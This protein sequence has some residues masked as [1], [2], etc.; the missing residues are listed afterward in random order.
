MADFVGSLKLLSVITKVNGNG[1]VLTI[2][3]PHI[4]EYTVRRFQWEGLCSTFNSASPVL[5]PTLIR[6]GKLTPKDKETFALR[7]AE[8][9]GKTT[10][11]PSLTFF[12]ELFLVAQDKSTDMK[13]SVW[14]LCFLSD[15]Q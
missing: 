8:T 6:L 4:L 10:F 3:S 12:H 15:I 14:S 7:H 9:D 11:L 1:K 5:I 13:Q 2:F